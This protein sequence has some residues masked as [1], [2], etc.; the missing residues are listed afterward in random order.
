MKA[1]F[2][3]VNRAFAFFRTVAQVMGSFARLNRAFAF[4]AAAVFFL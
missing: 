3:K 1:R 4:Q 2:A